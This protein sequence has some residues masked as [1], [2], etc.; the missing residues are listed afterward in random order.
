MSAYEN[1]LP[2]AQQL[3]RSERGRRCLDQ[4]ESFLDSCW[5]LDAENELAVLKLAALFFQNPHDTLDA[6]REG[7]I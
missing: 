7:K 3:A 1:A 4:L 5:S 6:I 2:Q